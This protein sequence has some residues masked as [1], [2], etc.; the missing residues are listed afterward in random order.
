[1]II[2]QKLLHKARKRLAALGIADDLDDLD[3]VV[4]D[5]QPPVVRAREAARCF[6]HDV[7]AVGGGCEDGDVPDAAVPEFLGQKGQAVFA[8]VDAGV[9]RDRQVLRHGCG[10]LVGFAVRV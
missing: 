1:M 5:A 10:G 9:G 4:T 6:D 7:A 8:V 2:L 3:A